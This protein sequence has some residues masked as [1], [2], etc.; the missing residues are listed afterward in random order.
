MLWWRMYKNV[1][2][3]AMGGGMSGAAYLLLQGMKCKFGCKTQK[4]V[5][6]F[7]LSGGVKEELRTSQKEGRCIA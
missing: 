1:F 5:S 2:A 4:H 6:I 3:D 7:V